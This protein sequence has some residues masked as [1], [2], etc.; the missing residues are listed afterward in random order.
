MVVLAPSAHER[1]AAPLGSLDP[2]VDVSVI[3]VNWNTRDLLRTCLY[4]LKET[5]HALEVETIVVDNASRDGSVEMIQ[6]EFSDVALLVNNRN[7]G[8]AA[9][10]NQALGQAHGRH[11]LL[12]NSDTRVLPGAVEEMVAHMDA[13]PGVGA[14]GPRLLNENLSVQASIRGFPRLDDTVLEMLDVRRWPL[15][16]PLARRVQAHTRASWS[17][18]D[19]TREVDWVMGACLLLR[20]E[21]LEA[22]GMLDEGYFFFSEEV[23]LCYRLRQ[24]GWQVVFLASAHIVHLGG[25]SAARVPAARLVWHYKGVL[26]FY[27]RHHGR[28]SR[29]IVRG[30]IVVSM[31]QRIV[32]LLLRHRGASNFRPLLAAYARILALAATSQLS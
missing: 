11:I 17:D 13:H 23:D 21:A 29:L 6:G 2:Q 14:I 5:I 24:Q 19:Q 26:R 12:L 10:N 8:F 7:R 25:R 4:T 15:V 20:R 1:H 30:A 9:A 32:W 18:H 27:Q 22:V 31:I 28:A 3:V 16:G